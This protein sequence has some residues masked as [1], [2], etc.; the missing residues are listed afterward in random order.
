[1]MSPRNPACQ[2][3]QPRLPRGTSWSLYKRNWR[4]LGPRKD[5]GDDT[6]CS[7]TPICLDYK[8]VRDESHAYG[9]LFPCVGTKRVLTKGPAVRSTAMLKQ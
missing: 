2:D 6:P 4:S 9:V 7:Q 1:M 5:Q 8:A 3:S